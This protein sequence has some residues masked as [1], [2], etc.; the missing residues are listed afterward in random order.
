MAH[1]SLSLLGSF[2][3]NLDGQPVTGFDTLKTRALLAYLANT[4]G[5]AHSRLTLASL[6]WP[7]LSEIPALNNLRHILTYLRRVIHDQQASPRFLLINRE[8]IALNIHSDCS[9]D[10][11]DFRLLIGSVNDCP[12]ATNPP[13]EHLEHA[14]SLYQGDFLEAFYL[15]DSPIF[16]EWILS[17]REKYQTQVL[18]A[19]YEL[20]EAYLSHGKYKQAKAYARRQIEIEPWREEAYQQLMKALALDGKRSEALT[21]YTLCQARLAKDL[22]VE[23]SQVTNQLYKRIKE[24]D[25]AS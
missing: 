6:L 24:G 5:R 9:V 3:A 16:E 25:L 10:T 2:Q 13:L 7:G 8:T 18:E 12:Q 15:R 4:P 22:S 20:V 1:L 23:P 14:V 17:Q 11:H 19:L 21:Q